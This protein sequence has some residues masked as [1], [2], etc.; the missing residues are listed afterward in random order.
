MRRISYSHILSCC[1]LL[2]FF[3]MMLSSQIIAAES[4]D[5]NDY[6][7]YQEPKP[8]GGFSWLSTIAYIFTLLITFLVVIGLAYFVSRFLGQKMGSLSVV[9]DNKILAT[10]S[11]GPN[12]GI[13]V[14]Q[15]AEKCFII[16]VTDHS[17]NLLQ[18]ITDKE[19]I[20]RLKMQTVSPATGQFDRI[21]QRHIA[22]LQQMSHKFSTVFDVR[23]NIQSESENEREKR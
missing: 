7:K 17:I 21:F 5:N 15:I 11:L 8:T 16:G 10:L 22:S 9:G 6:L 23:Q 2:V 14:I 1:V 13:Y 18:E 3:T 19:E 20:E 4:P 12:R